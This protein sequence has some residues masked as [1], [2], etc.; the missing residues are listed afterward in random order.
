MKVI[1]LARPYIFHIDLQGQWLSLMTLFFFAYVFKQIRIIDTKGFPIMAKGM[2]DLHLWIFTETSHYSA[3]CCAL[4]I[5]SLAVDN[6]SSLG[7]HNDDTIIILL[8]NSM[9]GWDRGHGLP[10]LSRVWQHVKLSGVSL[11]TLPQCSLVFDEDI[12]KPTKQS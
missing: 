10:A 4:M 6:S 5:A 12:K 8:K 1:Q 3:I 2:C 11:R 9:N 7:F